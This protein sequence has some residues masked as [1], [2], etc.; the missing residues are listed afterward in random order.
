MCSHGVNK[1]DPTTERSLLKLSPQYIAE[2]HFRKYTKNDF[3]LNLKIHSSLNTILAQ[4]ASSSS[5][6]MSHNRLQIKSYP[7]RKLKKITWLKFLRV[8][9]PM[10]IGKNT[11][12]WKVL[13][14]LAERGAPMETWGD[15]GAEN[16]ND[17]LLKLFSENLKQ[18]LK[19]KV[20][21]RS[22]LNT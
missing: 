18:K 22:H 2:S 19:E 4:F 16:W 13:G 20:I 21:F 1:T 9:N 6:P 7:S 3:D 8:T 11:Q 12:L 15:Y 10:G 5:P 17:V 14:I